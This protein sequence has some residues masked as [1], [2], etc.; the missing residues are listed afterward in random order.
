[1][2]FEQ[3]CM[4][5]DL[6]PVPAPPA[7][8]AKF[9]ADIAPLGIEKVWPIVQEISRAH[10]LAGLADPTLGGPVAMAIN[11]IAKIQPPRSWPTEQ[12]R[13]FEALPYD[14]Q[15][16]VAAHDKQ[17]ENT[18]RKALN[19]AADARKAIKPREK[20]HGSQTAAA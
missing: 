16:Y 10:Y 18:V 17:R 9:I 6:E 13:R 19:E 2:M 20:E 5:H 3:W 1:M 11:D 8:V 14:L 7:T 12:K 15:A 4:L